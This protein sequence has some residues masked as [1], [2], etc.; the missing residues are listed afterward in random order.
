MSACERDPDDEELDV[1]VT[2]GRLVISIGVRTLAFAVT[3]GAGV[4]E[5]MRITD[6]LA[7]AR[8]MVSELVREEED[9][10]TPVH[11]LLDKAAFDAWENGGDGFDQVPTP[12]PEP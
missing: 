4:D 2:G 7:A 3:H 5:V 8:E 11:K 6:P 12:A 1:A 10:T 9:G